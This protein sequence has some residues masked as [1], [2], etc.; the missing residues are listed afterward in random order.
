MITPVWSKSH[1]QREAARRI[2]E[3]LKKNQAAHA[4]KMAAATPPA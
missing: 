1:Q 4:A 2:T 3:N